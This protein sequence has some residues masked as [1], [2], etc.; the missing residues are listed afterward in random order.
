MAFL[1]TDICI[2]GNELAGIVAGALLAHSGKRVVVIDPEGPYET[3]PIKDYLAPTF[4]MF[5]QIPKFGSLL[6]IFDALEIRT[7]LRQRF[8]PRS[9][10]ALMLNEEERMTFYPHAAN[11]RKELVRVFGQEGDE[12]F[13]RLERLEPWREE[14]RL[15]KKMA[16]LEYSLL[17]R[18]IEQRRAAQ[19]EHSEPAITN[20]KHLELLKQTV[21]DPYIDA[22]R[23]FLRYPSGALGNNNAGAFDVA[24]QF[25]ASGA[26]LPFFPGES[27]YA[28]LRLLFEDAIL[29]HGGEILRHTS[30]AEI[31]GRGSF[32]K[33]IK[34]NGRKHFL[35]NV[36]INASSNN[37]LSL[38]LRNEKQATCIASE[39]EAFRP[40]GGATILRW[41]LPRSAL[42]RAL[43]SLAVH[44]EQYASPAMLGL[45]QGRHLQSSRVTS[46]FSTEHSAE[47]APVVAVL[48]L[49]DGSE[50]DAS[51][52]MQYLMPFAKNHLI[53][54]DCIEKTHSVSLWPYY[55]N[56]VEKGT[57]R[58][59]SMYSKLWNIFRAG[60]DVAPSLGLNGELM[61]GAQAAKAT[62][63]YL[64]STLFKVFGTKHHDRSEENASAQ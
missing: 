43:P 33:C 45:F 27:P 54:S 37:Q 49:L 53:A 52:R 16:S 12:L 9:E 6:P 31:E 28:T 46:I 21:L 13:L 60:R 58:E 63:V 23:P 25:L 30:V 61:V 8:L 64:D 57:V 50:E 14:L 7:E 35:P 18:L 56:A 38:L 47:A 4:P 3:A 15:R 42:P 34:T 55:K 41:L 5:W 1:H 59:R 48:M 20:E 32:I 39:E 2:I 36:V 26:Q 11:W 40:E 19:F 10:F 51:R 62:A 44:T 24:I 29:R 17:A 22:L